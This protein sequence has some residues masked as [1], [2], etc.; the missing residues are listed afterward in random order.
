VNDV[1]VR[2]GSIEVKLAAGVQV[3]V[4]VGLGVG[5]EVGVAIKMRSEQ[6]KH[7]ICM[8]VYACIPHKAYGM[9]L[10]GLWDTVYVYL[11]YMV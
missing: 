7:Y 10:Y 4:R 3:G 8:Y 9:R 5:V 1:G 2:F 6:T 11:Y